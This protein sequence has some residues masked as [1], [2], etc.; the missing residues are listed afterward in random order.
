MRSDAK[1]RETAARDL[2]VVRGQSTE[3]RL[4]KIIESTGRKA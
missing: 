1:P 4:R 3:G 2:G